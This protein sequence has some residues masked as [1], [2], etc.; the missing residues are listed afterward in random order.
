MTLNAQVLMSRIATIGLA[1]LSLTL[2]ACGGGSSSGGGSGDGGGGG[3]GGGSTPP[4]ASIV[5][6]PGSFDFGLVTEGNLEEVPAR[7]FTIRNNGTSSYS[8]SSIRLE[9]INSAEF[10]LDVSAGDSPCGSAVLPLGPGASCQVDVRFAARSFGDFSA[11][12]AVQSNDP[13]APTV[14]SALRG[15]YAE[16]Q[17]VN[18]A[19][20]Q[21][22]ACP[23]EVPAKVFVSVTDQGGFPVR[24]LGL[25]D[26]R[27]QELGNEAVLDSADSVAAANASISLSIMMDYSNTIK[28]S[29]GAVENMEEAASVLAQK[30]SEQ[31]EADIAKFSSSVR[32]MLDDFSSDKAAV[33]EAIA[34]DP[35]LGGGSAIYDAI[36]AV[37]DRLKVRTL[38]RKAV[39]ILTDG[40]DSSISSELSTVIA[41]AL[42]DDIPVFPVAF[43]NANAVDLTQL[44]QDTGGVFY[45]PAA[46][47]NLGAVYQQLANLLFEDQ[48]VLSYLSALPADTAAALEVF[49]EFTKDGK[50]FGGS[51]SKT[52]LAC[53]AI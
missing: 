46:A 37:I 9:G 45:E 5:I 29:P 22:N 43:G 26:F 11:T 16:V 39:V 40:R 12:L 7:R 2:V 52:L 41:A 6:Q 34:T 25:L 48:Y 3:G 1:S 53:P 15:S 23:R 38:D 31:D 47:E 10:D 14:S 36:L 4:T 8:L 21:I 32:F 30:L 51:G 28:N 49:V 35:G 18:V 44:A 50:I 33:L 42:E 20:S 19:V 17:E 24:G 27:L 13:V